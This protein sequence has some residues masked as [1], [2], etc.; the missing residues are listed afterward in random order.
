MNRVECCKTKDSVVFHTSEAAKAYDDLNEYVNTYEIQFLDCDKIVVAVALN[1]ADDK[2]EAV[3]SMFPACMGDKLQIKEVRTKYN[4]IQCILIDANSST[5]YIEAVATWIDNEGLE[6]CQ[7]FKIGSLSYL[8]R[9][10]GL[11]SLYAVK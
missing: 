8:S 4:D 10:F 6:D 5:N 1:V 3:R 11:F 7:I 9:V 2:E